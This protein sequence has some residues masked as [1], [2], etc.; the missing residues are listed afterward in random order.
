MGA[1]VLALGLVA[2]CTAVLKPKEDLTRFFVLGAPASA[3]AG[4][5]RTYT[6]SVGLMAVRLP[7][8]LADRRE[9]ATRAGAEVRYLSHWRWAESRD[10]ALAERLRL[11]LADRLRGAQIQRVPWSDRFRPAVVVSLD[12]ERFEAE[13]DG[14]VHLVAR[15][16]LL[17]GEARTP[18]A[19]GRF[20]NALPGPADD[21][22]SRV[23]RLGLLV[24]LLAAE[25]TAKIAAP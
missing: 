2:G 23:A 10:R 15:W 5:V 11:A 22:D 6:G 13:T 19:S 25:L 7:G 12:V 3:P 17:D 4:E 16:T 1:A 24:D 18:R 14:S 9:F 8:Y 21:P 20:S